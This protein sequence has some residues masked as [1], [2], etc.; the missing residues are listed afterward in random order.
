MRKEYLIE[1]LSKASYFVKY[2]LWELSE[3]GNKVKIPM[4]INDAIN[5][6]TLKITNDGEYNILELKK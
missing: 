5:D 4:R 3:F 2:L 1:D 6:A